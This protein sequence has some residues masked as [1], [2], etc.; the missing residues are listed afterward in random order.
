MSSAYKMVAVAISAALTAVAGVFHAFYYNN[1][2]PDD[3][4]AIGRSIEI[5][6]GA[7][8]RRARHAVRPHPRRL[9]C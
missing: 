6:T 2:F 7:D 9:S 8:H 1:L 5:I 4:F 3:S